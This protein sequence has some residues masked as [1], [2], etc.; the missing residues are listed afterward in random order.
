[1]PKTFFFQQGLMEIVY[2][3]LKL[4][5][6]VIFL[7]RKDPYVDLLNFLHFQID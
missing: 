6:M 5:I 7:V 3:F 4:K 1:M 2:L